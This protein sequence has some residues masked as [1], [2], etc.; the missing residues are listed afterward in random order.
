MG[1]LHGTCCLKKDASWSP[2]SSFLVLWRSSKL[3]VASS[4]LVST[5]ARLKYCRMKKKRTC[6]FLIFFE[7]ATWATIHQSQP[8]LQKSRKKMRIVR[9]TKA[10]EQSCDTWRGNHR[11][12]TPFFWGVGCSRPSRPRHEMST[13]NCDF[14]ITNRNGDL[15]G[16]SKE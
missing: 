2:A 15:M 16:C 1:S 3:R 10:G 12:F 13:Q 4:K 8:D 5:M 6:Y 11:C 14:T 7:G 9:Q